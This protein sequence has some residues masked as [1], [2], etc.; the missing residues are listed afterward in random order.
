M[1]NIKKNL[2]QPASLVV[3]LTAV[4]SMVACQ[5]PVQESEPSSTESQSTQTDNVLPTDSSPSDEVTASDETSSSTQTLFE[6]VW[7]GE[8][9]Q[10]NTS[11]E[12]NWSIKIDFTPEGEVKIDYPSLECGGQ[13]SVLNTGANHVDFREKI[14]Y[15]VGCVDNG[16]ITLTKEDENTVVFQWYDVE[17]KEGASGI[18]SKIQ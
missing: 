4:L 1:I 12:Q 13:L 16:Q 9:T 8:A 3:C 11:T 5:A 18:L 15:G 7:E 14:S 10:Y 6:G 17:G 2:R